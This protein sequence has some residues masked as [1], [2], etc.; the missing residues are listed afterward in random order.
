MLLLGGDL[1][2]RGASRLAGSFGV[3]PL[4]VGLT[5][6]AFG[7]SA[8]ELAVNVLAAARAQLPPLLAVERVRERLL[9]GNRR[10]RRAVDTDHDAR[11]VHHLEHV[12]KAL[13]RLA[14][15]PAAA[16]PLIPKLER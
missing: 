6:V 7:T 5:V 16:V 10:G 1:L 4:A 3:S 12:A 14:Y 15:E 11:L 9:I 13:V 8:P 2:V